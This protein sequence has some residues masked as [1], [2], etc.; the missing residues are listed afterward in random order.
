MPTASPSDR[1][2]TRNPA[3]KALTLR[4]IDATDIDP[5]LSP[6]RV[7]NALAFVQDVST[8]DSS[9]LIVENRSFF[10]LV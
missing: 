5:Q 6:N 2:W 9:P 7:F 8:V 1:P 3:A 4:T 10:T